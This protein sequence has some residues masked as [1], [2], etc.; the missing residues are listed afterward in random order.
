MIGGRG[1][2]QGTPNRLKHLFPDQLVIIRSRFGQRTFVAGPGLILS[3]VAAVAGLLCWTAFATGLVL[4]NLTG[5]SSSESARSVPEAFSVGSLSHEVKQLRETAESLRSQAN[6]ALD[7]YTNAVGSVPIDNLSGTGGELAAENGKAIGSTAEVQ[8]Q[9]LLA[10][11]DRSVQELEDTRLA[12]ARTEGDL[13]ALEIETM[14]LNEKMSRL[15]DRLVESMALASEGL[16]NIFRRLNLS[17]ETM[18]QEA[19]RL[20]SG[21]GGGDSVIEYDSTTSSRYEGI[22]SDL[23]LDTLSSEINRMNLYRLAFLSIPAGHPVDGRN[24]YTSGFGVRMHPIRRTAQ[25]HD[26]ADFAAPVGTDVVSTADG[27]VTF[28]G[29]EGGFGRTIRIRHIN[30]IETVYGHLSKIRVRKGQRVARGDH[31]GDIGSTG[32]STGPHLHYEVRIGKKPVDPIPF[33]RAIEY[34]YQ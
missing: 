9:L 27:T 22:I 21:I 17:P 4:W 19:R 11:L 15:V 3:A 25:H 31:I 13:K 14:L 2:S 10:A 5:L 20:Y 24:R 26:G 8:I 16:E 12:H 34:V 33:I 18:A 32:Q 1:R 28:A 23:G 30:G 29:Y 6:A 7:L